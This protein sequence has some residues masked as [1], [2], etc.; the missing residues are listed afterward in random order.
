MRITI[1]VVSLFAFGCTESVESNDVRTSGVYP[2]IAVTATGNGNSQVRVR[3]KVGGSNSNTFLDMTGEDRLEATVGD[4]TKVLD[5]TSK[6]TYTASFPTD[7]EGTEFTI[8]FLR[9][10]SDDDA[11]ASTVTMPAPFAMELGATTAA[12]GMDD[13]DV[14]WDPPASGSSIAWKLSGECVK[15]DSGSTPDDGAYTIEAGS[16]ETFEADMDKS[17]T[18]NFEMTRSKMGTVDPAF[19]EGGSI[20]ARHV[21]SQGFTSTP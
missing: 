5:E 9:G 19:T 10:T 17:C 21:R 11:P 15:L 2:E 13:L 4:D 8:A 14:T 1:A 18:V 20:V 16:I 12:R 3:L 7:E 6:D